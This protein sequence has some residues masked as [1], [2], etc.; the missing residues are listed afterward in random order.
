M[1]HALNFNPLIHAMT[2]GEFAPRGWLGR[3][4][5]AFAQGFHTLDL[6]GHISIH[7]IGD[8]LCD[9]IL[10]Q[11]GRWASLFGREDELDTASLI[12]HIGPI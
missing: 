6:H 12:F 10:A 8:A 7:P 2:A 4:Q 11:R 1:H 3:G 5:V 9:D